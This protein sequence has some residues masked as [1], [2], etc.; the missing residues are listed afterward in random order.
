MA[1][2]K[3]AFDALSPGKRREYADHVAEAKRDD[4]KARRVEKILPMIR[5]GVGLH[6]R[7]R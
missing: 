3:K 6:D 2:A 4:T 5:S 1:N 7:Y